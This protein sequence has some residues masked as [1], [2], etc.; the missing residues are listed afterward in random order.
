[1]NAEK[2][3]PLKAFGDNE[4]NVN[5]T[6]FEL[7]SLLVY[8]DSNIMKEMG[9]DYSIISEDIPSLS[10]VIRIR[11]KLSKQYQKANHE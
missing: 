3:D 8:L 6:S 4:V 5:L 2:T 7:L 9:Q 11:H 10:E 1:M